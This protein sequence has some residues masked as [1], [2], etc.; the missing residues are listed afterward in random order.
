M[1]A[2]RFTDSTHEAK[3]IGWMSGRFNFTT[4]ASGQT[5]IP[6]TA[7]AA[8]AQLGFKF[9]VEGVPTYAQRIP[10]VRVSTPASI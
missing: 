10:Q 7:L 2:I 8:L 4:L 1:V 6:E 5:L 3:A 9:A